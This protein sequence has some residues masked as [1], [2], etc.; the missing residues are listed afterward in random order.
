MESR[1]RAYMYSN[2]GDH[3]KYMVYVITVTLNPDP[4]ARLANLVTAGPDSTPTGADS[5]IHVRLWSINDR[6]S[7]SG[8]PCNQSNYTDLEK[9]SICE[10]NGGNQTLNLGK[11]LGSGVSIGWS[12]SIPTYNWCTYVPSADIWS[13]FNDYT[14]QAREQSWTRITQQFAFA[15]WEPENCCG[16]QFKIGY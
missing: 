12:I 6:S 10:A 11:D 5:T 7:C 3:E 8:T 16:N 14:L 9:T 13:Q 1:L 15:Q 2:T 4:D